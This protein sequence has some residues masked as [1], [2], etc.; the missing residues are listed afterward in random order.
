MKL[1]A[2]VRCIHIKGKTY[3]LPKHRNKEKPEK[4]EHLGSWRDCLDPQG[5]KIVIKNI[6][7]VKFDEDHTWVGSDREAPLPFA[8]LR[9]TPRFAPGQGPP[10][11]LRI[12]PCETEDYPLNSAPHFV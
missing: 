3:Y 4:Y 9:R 1:N 6:K 11:L 2:P 10:S 5:K 8:S 7:T 12:A